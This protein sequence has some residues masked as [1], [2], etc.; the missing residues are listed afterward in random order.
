MQRALKA[1][2]GLLRALIIALASKEPVTGK[3][4]IEAVKER[5]SGQWVPSPGSVYYIIERLLDEQMLIP[6]PHT[7]EKRYIT[8]SKGIEKLKDYSQSIKES[9]K[10][11]LLLLSILASLI[12]P[13]E[14][15]R[16]SLMMK[17]VSM[18]DDKVNRILN[19]YF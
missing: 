13:S 6:M 15:N 2:Q 4:V 12:E 16:I 17:I 1:P 18:P 19:E 8:T 3:D 10:R 7:S 11:N 9:I 14:M 5:S